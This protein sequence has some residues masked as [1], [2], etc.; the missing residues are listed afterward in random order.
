MNWDR[1]SCTLSQE[2]EEELNKLLLTKVSDRDPKVK[3]NIV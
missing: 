2:L 3:V 1:G